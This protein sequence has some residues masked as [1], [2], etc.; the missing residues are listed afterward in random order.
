MEHVY[1]LF[2]CLYFAGDFFLGAE[3]QSALSNCESEERGQ[4][5]WGENEEKQSL[6][7]TKADKPA[8]WYQRH[9]KSCKL[10]LRRAL[11]LHKATWDIPVH[12]RYDRKH[13]CIV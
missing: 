7:S 1:F 3:L 6:R 12:H 5:K 2:C 10:E 4:K 9:I 13:H 11:I 8:G